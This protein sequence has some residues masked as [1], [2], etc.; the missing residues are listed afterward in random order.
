MVP[1]R[2]DLRPFW[3]WYTVT[4]SIYAS[5]GTVAITHGGIEL[6]QGINVKVN[7][8]HFSSVHSSPLKTDDNSVSKDFCTKIVAK[9][10]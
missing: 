9:V 3:Q 7:T 8:L 1:G 10:F 6:G 2:F 4:V 5:D